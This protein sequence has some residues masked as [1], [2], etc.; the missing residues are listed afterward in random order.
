MTTPALDLREAAAEAEPQARVIRQTPA[1]AIVAGSMLGI[2][3]FLAPPLVSQAVASPLA[4]LLVWV[5]A[6]VLAIAGA[7]AYCELGAM[8]PR[9]GGDYVFQ[10]EA[11]GPSVAFATGVVLFGAVFAGSIAAMAVGVCQF[12]LSVLLG[13]DPAGWGVDLPWGSRLTGTHGLA[14]SLVV[15]MTALNTAGSRPSA[16]GQV[17]LA[18]VPLLLLC[19]GAVWALLA[20]TPAAREVAAPNVPASYSAHGL[21]VAYMAAYFAFSGWNAVAYVAGEVE[22]PHRVLPRA[23]L[24]GT[25]LIGGV[26]LLACVAMVRVLGLE[27]LRESR[28]VGASVVEAAGAPEASTLVT[29]LVMVAVLASLNASIFG[30]SRIGFAMGRDGALWR[31]LGR[32]GSA[33]VPTRALWMQAGWATVLILTGSF[34]QILQAVSLAMVLTGSLTVGALFVLRWRSPTVPRPYRASGYP[35]LPLLYLASNAVVIGVLVNGVLTTEDGWYPLF[36][37]VLLA[38]AYASHRLGSG[39]VAK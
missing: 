22:H 15:L 13:F 17:V 36:G 5:A 30:G 11:Y 14:I 8:M 20:A 24:R 28:D 10:R 31:A 4:F 2:G 39:V 29:F 6:G 32:T 18:G 38:M 9:A 25:L 19:L 23:I 35:W 37:L 1:T 7:V 16:A 3:I 27:G 26:Y 33:G 21:V 34:E 12:Q